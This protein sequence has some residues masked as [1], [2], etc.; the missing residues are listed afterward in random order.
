[1]SQK[2]NTPKG[3]RDFSSFE[4]KK[5]DYLLNILK[6]CFKTFNFEEIQTPSFE[7]LTTLT[8]KYGDEEDNLI[9]KILSSGDKIK[10]ADTESLKE[11]KLTKF[12][13]SLS[14]KALRYDLTVPLS[15]FVSQ[16]LNN[17]SFPF[18]RFQT[19]LVWRAERP[20]RGRY[21][22]FLQCDVDIIGESNFLDEVEC[23]KV[24]DTVF[25]RLRMPKVNLRIN[26]R[27]IL[28]GI[29]Q[30]MNLD[31]VN[32]IS[33]VLDKSDKIGVEG[34]INELKKR[35]LPDSAIDQLIFFLDLNGSN[36]EKIKNLRNKFSLNKIST[37]GIDL[38]EKIINTSQKFNLNNVE[39]IF[40]LSLA[41]GLSYYTGTIIEV[42]SPEEF[43]IGSIGG[44]GRYD[45]LIQK[46]NPR[47]S[48]FGIS[49]GFDRIS[50]I[51]DELNLFPSELDSS[52][53]F[54]FLN[55][56]IEK[57]HNLLVFIDEL[58][59]KNIRCELYPS[60]NKIKKQMDY[61]NQRGI[62]YVVLIGEEELNKNIF[63]LKDMSSGKESSFDLNNIVSELEKLS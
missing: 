34:V 57:T 21:R 39:L 49:F 28:E 29:S 63:K 58:R 52:K 2:L 51:L 3:T 59:E 23:I 7:N 47:L 45:N 40:D 4:L 1:M 46:N 18:K 61:A 13:N 8:G 10:K 53:S 36:E 31:S 25:K 11:N 48:G 33:S 32:Q 37:D 16:N 12:S 44:G 50:L 60:D 22:E 56:G 54:L 26:N 6:N 24:Y 14:D 20:Q 19:Q 43:N 5:R 15:R 27:Q 35:N 38:L 62:D 17:L 55:F 41:R 30:L 42:S 9:F